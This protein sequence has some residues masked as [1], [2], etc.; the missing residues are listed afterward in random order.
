MRLA[1]T[2]LKKLVLVLLVFCVVCFFGPLLGTLIFGIGSGQPWLIVAHDLAGVPLLFY[3]YLTIGRWLFLVAIITFV[4]G[5]VYELVLGTNQ[6]FVSWLFFFSCA[7]ACFGALLSFPMVLALA[8][9][10]T[11]SGLYYRL[12]WGI[13]GIVTGV[14][15]GMLLGALWFFLAER[16]ASDSTQGR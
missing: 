14:I 3:T 6:P 9:D 13:T 16:D 2:L 1:I 11:A 7:G 10:N 4:F 12:L 15:S 8:S 5:L